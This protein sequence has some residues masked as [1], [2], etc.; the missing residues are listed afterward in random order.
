M[1]W[2]P[3]QGL[4][5]PSFSLICTKF[6]GDASQH[7]LGEEGLHDAEPLRFFDHVPDPATLR[8]ELLP[9]VDIVSDRLA[10]DVRHIIAPETKFCSQQERDQMET[11]LDTGGDLSSLVTVTGAADAG[12][13]PGRSGFVS[14]MDSFNK[15]WRAEVQ[16]LDEICHG[17]Y[18]RHAW[19][20]F[21]RTPTSP[22]MS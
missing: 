8:P 5:K 13:L 12:G 20:L 14:C 21:S 1:C 3:L 17:P 15:T 10:K 16:L 4:V 7:W 22:R 6:R 2:R 18:R 19:R 9:L 11:F